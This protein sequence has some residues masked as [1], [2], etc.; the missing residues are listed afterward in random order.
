VDENDLAG[1]VL[2][3]RARKK[4]LARIDRLDGLAALRHRAIEAIV[5]LGRAVSLT[6]GRL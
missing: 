5:V 2:G 6:M 3:D 1:I 4:G